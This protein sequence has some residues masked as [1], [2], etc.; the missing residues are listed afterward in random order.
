MAIIVVEV[1]MEANHSCI[2]ILE[3]MEKEEIYPGRMEIEAVGQLGESTVG[4]VLKSNLVLFKQC[5]LSRW[6]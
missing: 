2:L 4:I 5:L 3:S 1:D 6:H